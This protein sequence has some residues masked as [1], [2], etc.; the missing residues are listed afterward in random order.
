M[1]KTCQKRWLNEK[2]STTSYDY[3]ISFYAKIGLKEK[4]LI[5]QRDGDWVNIL[6]NLSQF[7]FISWKEMLLTLEFLI[8]QRAEDLVNIL[9]ILSQFLFSWKEMP[10]PIIYELQK[11][12]RCSELF[13]RFLQDVYMKYKHLMMCGFWDLLCFLFCLKLKI[14]VFS[15]QSYEHYYCF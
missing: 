5:R 11:W 12:I 9:N 10:L 4:R 3:G 1:E 15:K 14:S 8:R 2:L 6:K 13:G 7:I